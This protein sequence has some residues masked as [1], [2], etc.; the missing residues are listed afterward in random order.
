MRSRLPS[1]TRH[2][3]LSREDMTVVD[4]SR[5]QSHRLLAERP[6]RQTI[7]NRTL[8][9]NRVEP[10]SGAVTKEMD[11][12]LR[13]LF[14]ESHFGDLQTGQKTILLL[15]WPTFEPH[16]RHPMSNRVH[17]SKSTPTGMEIHTTRALQ[18]TRFRVLRTRLC[19]AWMPQ[20][21][22]PLLS[23]SRDRRNG[24]MIVLYQSE[25]NT[26]ETLT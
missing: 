9:N 7:D 10:M 13:C 20:D 11:R 5:L 21:D 25:S 22:K 12:Q 2:F 26:V 4:S 3:L 24:A 15:C 6:G 23:K 17:P 18:I 16:R 8:K 1:I 19:P 14:P